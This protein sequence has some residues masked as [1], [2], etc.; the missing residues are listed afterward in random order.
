MMT[1]ITTVVLNLKNADL[2]NGKGMSDDL[3]KILYQ[4][5]VNQN[6]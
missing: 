5:L 4:Q 2:L 1:L 6:Y 3:K